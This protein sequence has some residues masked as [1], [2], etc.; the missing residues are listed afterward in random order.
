M[1]DII[2]DLEKHLENASQ[3]YQNMESFRMNLEE[4]DEWRNLEKMF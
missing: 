2:K 4:L 1:E 3:V